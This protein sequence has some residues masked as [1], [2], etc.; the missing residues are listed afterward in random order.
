MSFI[1]HL[2]VS[3]FVSHTSGN[4]IFCGF[5]KKKKRKKSL[6]TQYPKGFKTLLYVPN[7]SSC[8]CLPLISHSILAWVCAS[9]LSSLMA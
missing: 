8:Y 6:E 4:E 7:I 9:D 2:G 3:D 1:P 5:K